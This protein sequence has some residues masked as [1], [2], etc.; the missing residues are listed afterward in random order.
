MGCSRITSNGSRATITRRC[1][2]RTPW[3]TESV[4]ALSR[5]SYHQRIVTGRH[6]MPR[7]PVIGI[8]TQTLPAVVGER[9]A[10]WVMGQRYVEVLR[11]VGAVPW[12]IPLLPRDPDTMAEI[13][14]RL[15]GVFLTGGLDV[16]PSSYGEERLP[17]C[18]ATDPDRDAVE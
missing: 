13:F 10:C 8:A 14:D 4:D 12:L 7:R 17:V 15:D 3:P 9:P 18:G 1:R 5:L 16:D 2:R 11:A 6:L